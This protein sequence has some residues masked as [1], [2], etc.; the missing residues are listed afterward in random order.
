[1]FTKESFRSQ[2]V[3]FDTCGDCGH[4]AISHGRPVGFSNAN[5]RCREEACNCKH[6]DFIPKPIDATAPTA[7]P[8]LK[9]RQAIN[10]TRNLDRVVRT[11]NPHQRQRRS[12]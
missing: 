5:V 7:L 1:M 10:R 12:A 8:N 2:Q 6:R 3:D 4:P 11:I 9:E